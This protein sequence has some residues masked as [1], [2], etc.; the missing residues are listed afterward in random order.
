MG[1]AAAVLAGIPLVGGVLSGLVGNSG[2]RKAGE[3]IYNSGIGARNDVQAATKEATGGINSATSSGQ[4]ALAAIL[5]KLGISLPAAGDKSA[6]TINT[7]T[8]EAN[9]TLAG[10]FNASGTATQP[11]IDAGKAGIE[12]LRKYSEGPESKFNFSLDDYFNGPAYQFQLEQ[13]QRGIQNSASAGGLGQSGAALKELTKFGQG[14]GATYYNDAFNRAKTTFDT[15]N[16]A[17]MQ[18]FGALSDLGKFGTAAYQSGLNTFGT[19]MATNTM[20]AG[21]LNSQNGL[22]IQKLLAQYGLQGTEFGANLGLQGATTAGQ[23]GLQGANQAAGLQM[24]AAA[25]R[26]AGQVGGTNALTGLIANTANTLPG[27]LKSL[28]GA[29]GGGNAGELRFGG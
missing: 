27:F 11:Y 15:N 16:T 25:G 8:G 26:A 2:V 24:Q 9:N 22:D 3:T 1:T 19:P 29:G 18:K 12:G 20:N 7:A 6:N 14:L 17:T 13:G 21:V 23:L 4:N 5:E 10:L 28:G